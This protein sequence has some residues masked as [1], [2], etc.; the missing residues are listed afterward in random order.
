MHETTLAARLAVAFDPAIHSQVKLA[1]AARVSA[2]SVNDWL[3]GKTKTLRAEPL[4]RAALYLGVN[5]L[6]LACGSGPMRDSAAPPGTWQAHETRAPYAR[7][8]WP[9][10]GLSEAA[11]CNLSEADR[12]RIEGAVLMLLHSLSTTHASK[13]NQAA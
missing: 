10:S 3:S 5:P 6:W 12:L 9:F 13:A 8:P 11:V 4:V 7:P 2:P 1:K